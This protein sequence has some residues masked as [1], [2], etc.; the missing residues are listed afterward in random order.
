MVDLIG[1]EKLYGIEPSG[2]V[3]SY[4]RNRYLTASPN[5]LGY[6]YVT[7]TK[8]GKVEHARLN[9]LVATHFLGVPTSKLEVNHIDGNKSNNNMSNLEWV[10]R[11]QNV[12]HSY[13]TGLKTG[14]SRKFSA[15]DIK[16]IL[17]LRKAQ[18][19]YQ[20][21]ANNFGVSKT[22]IAKICRGETYH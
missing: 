13:D 8:D 1:Y 22:C 3:W 15:K 10:S 16:N 21:L 7:L 4:R 20:Q 2:R 6:H 18:F 12:K 19:S 14:H 5:N 9:R 11:S 17:E